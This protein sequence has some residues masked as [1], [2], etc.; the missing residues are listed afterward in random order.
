M[1]RGTFILW[2]HPFHNTVE[3]GVQFQNTHLIRLH[4]TVQNESYLKGAS[5][6]AISL[7]S[8]TSRFVGGISAMHLKSLA[9]CI[10]TLGS[11][12]LCSPLFERNIDGSP[13][14]SPTLGTHCVPSIDL[15]CCLT[16]NNYA[17][18]ISNSDTDSGTYTWAQI[19]CES[20]TDGKTYCGQDGTNAWCTSTIQTD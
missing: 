5:S 6:S 9:L 18:C 15:P 19:L 3:G 17:F 11:L 4:Q 10:I 2:A 20:N 13:T 7:L 16:I 1:W 14:C 8:N 12:G